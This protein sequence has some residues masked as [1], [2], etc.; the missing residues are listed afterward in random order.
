[1]LPHSRSNAIQS[2]KAKLSII[3]K[4]FVGGNGQTSAQWSLKPNFFSEVFFSQPFAALK[5]RRV[6][7][8]L[9]HRIPRDKNFVKGE[10]LPDD[11]VLQIG[12]SRRSY[13]PDFIQVLNGYP[14]RELPSQQANALSRTDI[15]ATNVHN[16]S[17]GAGSFEEYLLTGNVWKLFGRCA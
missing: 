4:S 9:K 17:V 5:V 6:V 3:L 15:R 2:A 13:I 11:E 7:L 8:S 1:M 12:C 10:L 14:G 16:T